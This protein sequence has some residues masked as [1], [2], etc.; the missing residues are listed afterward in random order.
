VIRY[1]QL[2][3]NIRISYAVS[4]KVLGIFFNQRNSPLE[5]EKPLLVAEA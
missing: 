4:I 5:K 3:I 1:S 2:P